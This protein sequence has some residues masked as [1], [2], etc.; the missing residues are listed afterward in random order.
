MNKEFKLKLQHGETGRLLELSP[1]EKGVI[2]VPDGSWF[3]ISGQTIP[4][5]VCVQGTATLAEI[6]GQM[7]T[8]PQN[9]HDQPPRRTRLG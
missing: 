8:T 6:F 3:M 4:P 9:L 1:N 7:G 5:D 2:N